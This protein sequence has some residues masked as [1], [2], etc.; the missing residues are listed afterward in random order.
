MATFVVHEGV[1]SLD[2][3]QLAQLHAAGQ[4]QALSGSIVQALHELAQ[5]LAR[6]E[7]VYVYPDDAVLTLAQA[8]SMF[9]ILLPNL[10]KRLDNGEIPFF[11]RGAERYVYIRDMIAYD[12][13]ERAE[14]RRLI[15]VIQQTSEEM[16]AY[17]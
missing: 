16:G 4:A 2:K 17:S 13:V 11:R 14:R 6:G 8:A 10:E 5:H 12:R 9:H 1:L 7:P 15:G 3:E